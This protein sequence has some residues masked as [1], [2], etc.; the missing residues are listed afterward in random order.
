M[1]VATCLMFYLVA[2]MRREARPEGRASGSRVGHL[3]TTS[4]L[5]VRDAEGNAVRKAQDLHLGKHTS[6]V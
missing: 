2:G 6:Y 1:I 5:M 3:L 4:D